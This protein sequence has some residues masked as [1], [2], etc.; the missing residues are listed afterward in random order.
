MVMDFSAS[1]GEEVL[2]RGGELWRVDIVL[3]EIFQTYGLQ[4]VSIFMLPHTL[5]ISTKN[6]GQ[7]TV[8]RQRTVGG[9][10]VNMDELSR[11]H[12]LIRQVQ[13][14]APDPSDLDG[15]LKQAVQGKTYSE[16]MTVLGMVIAL[17]SLNFIIGGDWK[18][19]I[20]VALGIAIVMGS[21]MYFS[22]ERGISKMVVCGLGSFLIGLIDMA[23]WRMG[24]VSD[25]YHIMVVT[26]IGLVPGI[27]LINSC[28]EMLCGRVLG[29]SLL[30][31]TAFME[32][33]FAVCGF[34]VS[35]SILRG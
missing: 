7:E 34:A 11:L 31:S 4:N 33:L 26:A 15:L 22:G 8:I 35:I 25:P 14:T 17:V 20:F 3:N 13:E 30:F 24:L 16:P 9:I 6:D 21:D 18:D 5:L 19:A 28:R 27:P 12:T 2:I 23:A 1:L 32:T 29:G 10:V